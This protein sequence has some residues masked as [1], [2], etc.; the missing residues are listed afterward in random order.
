MST[1]ALTGLR[2]YLTG[3]LSIADMNWLADELKGYVHKDDAL[4]PYTIDELHERIA[5]AERD[6]AE[7]RFLTSEELF[8]ELDKEFHFLE[9]EDVEN[10][11]VQYAEAV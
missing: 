3:T 6:F 4:E 7:G 5:K 1:Q 8:G 2:D 9:K 10:M 11:D